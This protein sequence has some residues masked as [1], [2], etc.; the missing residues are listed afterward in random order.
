MASHP[1]I[2]EALRG[3]TTQP[4]VRDFLAAAVTED[5]VSHA[6]LFLG[7]PGSGK[8]E[9]ALALAECVVCPQGG[10]HTCDE[11]LRVRHRTHPD[12]HLL[13]PASATG[14]LVSQ[15]RELIED[16]SLAPIRARSK[17]YVLDHAGLLRGA[18]ANALLKTIEEPPQG[19]VFIL[20]ART[21]DAVLPTIVSRCQQVPFR[22]VSP[23]VALAE[24]VRLSG[25]EGTDAKVALSVAGTPQRAV[26]YL[27]SASRREVRRQVVQL[28]LELRRD[29][30]WDVL[31][32]V[33]TLVEAVH[34]P[35]YLKSKSKG[36]K[37]AKAADDP[38]REKTLEE[39]QQEERERNA[40]YLTPKA[41]KQLEEAN[42]REL[43]ARERSG[44]MEALAAA[45]S[46]LR[47]V[48]VCCEEAG[49]DVVNEDVRDAAESIARATC[50]RGVLAALE[51]V[52]TAADS[53]THN[54]SPQLTLEVMFLSIKEALE[55]PPSYR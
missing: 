29:D 4:R 6:Y 52:G 28:I 44:M 35:I 27:S 23:T 34:A 47:D 40:D 2:P 54:V 17:V 26:E 24:V 8:M 49:A 11:C 41:M 14:Y 31:S 19:V 50:T 46:L 7:T 25:V 10:D 53:L 36:G 45:E 51:A 1:P 38:S 5:R 3:L 43:T 32:S 16:V 20:L 13:A 55:C 15:V 33:R 37:R 22:I 39:M 18:S 30:A 48:L 9:A 42:K 21:A 12:V